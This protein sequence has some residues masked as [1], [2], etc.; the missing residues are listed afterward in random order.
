M[1]DEDFPLG[2]GPCHAPLEV[3]RSWVDAHSFGALT[4]GKEGISDIEE[5][6]EDENEIAEPW[7]R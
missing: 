1:S 3:Q 6:A 2:C 4:G 7:S 5:D